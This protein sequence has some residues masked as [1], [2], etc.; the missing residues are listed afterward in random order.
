M[1]R[2]LFGRYHLMQ[3]SFFF[4]QPLKIVLYNAGCTIRVSVAPQ[5]DL[6]TDDTVMDLVFSHTLLFF[7]LIC[8]E[9]LYPWSSTKSTQV[10]YR[11]TQKNNQ[12]AAPTV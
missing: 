1:F 10:I 2:A 3:D 9:P 4:L 11:P 12:H 5:S 8:D 7:Y 6:Q